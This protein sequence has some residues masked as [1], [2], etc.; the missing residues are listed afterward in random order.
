[1][2]RVIDRFERL[3]VR[4][5]EKLLPK[6]GATAGAVL[7]QD[8]KWWPVTLP[9]APPGS[10]V[11]AIAASVIPAP[12][13]VRKTRMRSQWDLAAD[14]ATVADEE[15]LLADCDVTAVVVKTGA[16]PVA[17]GQGGLDRTAAGA[18]GHVLRPPLAVRASAGGPGAD[19]MYG[20]MA[21]SAPEAEAAREVVVSLRT[22]RPLA[23]A[24]VARLERVASD[25]GALLRS[26]AELEGGGCPEGWTEPEWRAAADVVRGGHAAEEAAEASRSLAGVAAA[27]QPLST[28]RS[29]RAAWAEQAHHDPA[30]LLERWLQGEAELLAGRAVTVSQAIWRADVEAARGATGAGDAAQHDGLPPVG[31]AAWLS[32]PL[33]TESGPLDFVQAH[34]GNVAILFAEAARCLAELQAGVLPARPSAV[35]LFAGSGA[36]TL[37]VAHLLGRVVTAELMPRAVTRAKAALAQLGA[38]AATAMQADLASEADCARVVEALGGQLPDV[39]L[40]NPPRTG[41]PGFAVATIRAAMRPRAIVYL[42]CNPDTL[43]RDAAALQDAGGAEGAGYVL[44]SAQPVDMFPHSPH[45]ETVAAFVREDLA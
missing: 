41:L 11:V 44:R 39:V 34:E 12:R 17:P 37:A 32:R 8:G 36:L 28:P 2:R 14:F 18:A 33:T 26:A 13:K 5:S 15:A 10:D 25:V 29:L 22:T 35:E 24:N 21:L 19:A 42:S 38:D 45:V 1:M 3:H 27:W 9:K 6:T 4:T 30:R 40:A 7:G 43:A 31:R 16:R 23:L 20:A